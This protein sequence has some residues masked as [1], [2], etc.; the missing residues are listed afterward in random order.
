MYQSGADGFLELRTGADAIVTKLSG[1]SGTT[2][3]T[4]APFSIG[5]T[6]TSAPLTAY[7]AT[8]A[9]HFSTNQSGANSGLCAYFVNNSGGGYSSFIYIGSAPGTD[10][11][12]GKN[13]SNPTGTTYHF[14]IVDSSNNL[15]M[16]I[17]NGTGAVTFSSSVTAT[18][19]YESSDSRLKNLIK[20][21]YRASG[22]ETIKPKLYI[23]DGR[24]EVGYFAQDVKDILST[25]V[26]IN[27]AGF[28]SLSYTQVHTAKIAII[29]DEVDVLKKEVAEL[30]IKLQKYEA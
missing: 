17:N 22:I 30:K 4:L 11:K 23:K 19:F 24:E 28:L 13:I 16:Q 20:D 2:G 3:Y 1:Y 15:R 10:W 7:G 8:L 18:A 29:E 5:T 9:A 27:D 26:S 14:E 25:A 21:N 6:G 12:I